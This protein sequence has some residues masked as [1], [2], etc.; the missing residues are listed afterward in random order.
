[1]SETIKLYIACHKQDTRL[2]DNSL[3]HPIQVGSALAPE[4]FSGMIQDDSGLNISD[5]NRSYC[6]LTAQY[7]AWKNDCAD[8]Y[9][10]LHYR[11][12]FNFSHTQFPIRHEPFIFGDVVFDKNDRE[13]LSQIEFD[14]ARIREVVL[15][16]D[17]IAPEPIATPDGASVY[18]QYRLS[19]G[20]HI[21]DFDIVLSI[22]KHKYPQIWKS[23]QKYLA[24]NKLYVCNM[25]VM[26]KDIFDSYCTF[27]FDVLA[28]HELLSD[29]EHYSPVARRVSGYLGERL[30]GIY[31]TYLFDSGYDGVELQRVYFKNTDSDELCVSVDPSANERV[32]GRVEFGDITRGNGCIYCSL[33]LSNDRVRPSSPS[34]SVA[35]KTSDGRSVPAKVVI[36]DDGVPVLVL[37]VL[38]ADQLATVSVVVDGQLLFRGS[39]LFGARTTALISKKNT[40]LRNTSAC[41]IR[42]CDKLPLEG[43][44]LVRVD[45]VIPDGEDRDLVQGRVIVPLVACR[46]ASE[47]IHIVVLNSLGAEINL[48]DWVCMGDH[49]VPDA[50][51]SSLL[52]RVVDFSISVSKTDSFCLWARFPDSAVNDGFQN[53]YGGSVSDFR[54]FW[55]GSTSAASNERDY[56]PWFRERHRSSQQELAWQRMRKFSIAP[57]FSI[58]VPLYHT[59]IKFLNEMVDSV[60]FQTYGNW[61]LILVN[62]TPD[63][64]EL[65][66]AVALITSGDK[67]VK[68]IVLDSNFG[69]TENTNYGIEAATGDFVCFLDHDDLLEPDAL[70]WYADA[71]SSCDYIDMLYCDEDKLL[72]ATFCQPFFKPN[73]NP[74]LLI[75]MNYVCHFLAV[76]RSVLDVL[77]LPGREYDGS[78]DWHM[79]FRIGEMA[80]AV[81]HVPR[82]LYHWRIHSNSTAASA[83]Q[84]EYTLDSSRLSVESH[85]SRCGI[86]GKVAE[87]PLVPRRFVFEADL[88]EEPLVSI[89][90]PNMDNIKVLN[91]CL[92]SIAKKTTY[93]NY[94][95]VIVENNSC[96]SATFEYYKEI[97]QFDERIRVVYLEGLDGFNFS[98][99][100]NF[101]VSESLG[102]YILLL[103]NDTQVITEDWIERLLSAI[104]LPGVGAVGARLLFPDAT[105]QH[106]GVTF[107][108]DGPCHIGY[109]RSSRDYGNMESM[110]NLRD[111]SAVTGACLLTTR[112]VYKRV[113]GFD[114]E[115]SVN[116]NDV[117][118]CLKVVDEG[119]RV[120]YC[121]LAQLYHYESVSRGSEK[122][123][124]KAIRFRKEKGMFMLKWPHIFE[125]GDPMG[126]PNLEAGDVYERIKWSCPVKGW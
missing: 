26:R 94:E 88:S 40:L 54:Q 27:L 74:D 90:I 73:W 25:F 38:D 114:E 43:D 8:Y 123:G 103:N 107:G 3:T 97:Q 77:E 117:D 17:F 1:M 122:R 11:R 13:S 70:Y 124:A 71:I 112:D 65:T 50:N 29:I 59:P 108:H 53:L 64:T 58:V 52:A 98:K 82:V 57:S 100:V 48:G 34:F 19:V 84:K 18:D 28:Q 32:L 24:Q 106:A 110:M 121:P 68:S 37:P 44:V 109:L 56:D 67:R 105:I 79:T 47:F 10:F 31:L 116:Y 23:A 6:E 120:V 9:G 22:V 96:Q 16:H 113:Q 39:H 93:R 12:Y 63:D 62:S 83:D 95:V 76:R 111:V 4:A 66:A 87:S 45:R 21:E 55:L 46:S 85:L 101:G 104:M 102:D 118:F 126:N 35:S 51:D 49:V 20:H 80:R 33:S 5:K 86:D 2:P 81:H 69:I 30:C 119:F 15:A 115:L 61:E 42:N 78:Q 125:E 60:L 91:R 36:T 41:S 72:D 7:W 14:E 89:V 75:A 92:L 99:I